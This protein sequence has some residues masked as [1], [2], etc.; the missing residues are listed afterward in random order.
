MKKIISVLISIT[1]VLVFSMPLYAADIQVIAGAGP[2]TKIVRLF[3]KEYPKQPAAKGYRISV[4]SKSAKHAG[5]IANSDH[6]LFGRTGRPLNKKELA[7]DK[8]EIFLAR[9]PIA[10]VVGNKVGIDSLS[11]KQVEGIMTGKHTNWSELG[12]PNAAIESI[13]R[14]PT[15]A[16]FTVLKKS[17]PAFKDSKF[18]R[19]VKKDNHVV[20]ILR[21]EMGSFSIGFGALPNFDDVTVLDVTGFSEGVSVGLVYDL[22][23]KDHAFVKGAMTFAKSKEWAK[24]VKTL[25][26]F[27][28]N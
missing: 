17:Y 1:L 25:G 8:A 20:N 10:F 13:G 28:P 22:K 21:S 2:S 4:P 26:V 16:L 12:G 27:P 11:I 24:K 6:Q 14:E 5:G 9:I 3:A 18:S 23:N 19:T 15:E 7:M